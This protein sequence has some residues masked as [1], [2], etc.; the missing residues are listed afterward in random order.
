MTSGLYFD[1]WLTPKN[2]T[3]VWPDKSGRLQGTLE[4]KI[5]APSGVGSEQISIKTPW[6]THRVRL[7]PGHSRKVSVQLRGERRANIVVSSERIG[8][9]GDGRIVIARARFR[10]VESAQRNANATRVES[11]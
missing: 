9:L 7:A 11:R 1:G 5:M 4:I 2:S 6:S 10:R 8:R 3:T